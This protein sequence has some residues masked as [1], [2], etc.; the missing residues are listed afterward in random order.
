MVKSIANVGRL[1]Y[2]GR[3]PGSR[4][5]RALPSVA[6]LPPRWQEGL[7]R[8]GLPVVFG[9]STPDHACVMV[10]PNATDT[11][12]FRALADRCFLHALPQGRIKGSTRGC[13]L[14]LCSSN[15]D[16]IDR[17]ASEFDAYQVMR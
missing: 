1:G 3:K 14:F 15:Q 5:D 4:E 16:E 10:T 17:F 12:W 6:D 13:A 11:R 7:S 9:K 2:V 8:V